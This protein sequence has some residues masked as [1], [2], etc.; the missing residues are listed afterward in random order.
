MT[1]QNQ[2][3]SNN[4]RPVTFPTDSV[5]GG[6]N[7]SSF[8]RIKHL[9]F[10]YPFRPLISSY[11]SCRNFLKLFCNLQFTPAYDSQRRSILKTTEEIWKKSYY[12]NMPFPQNPTR[13][14]SR[15]TT[16]VCTG[17]LDLPNSSNKHMLNLGLESGKPTSVSNSSPATAR[18]LSKANRN[19][20]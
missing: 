14:K 20:R 16:K 8:D 5:T 10:R 7:T 4:T 9:S 2:P 12:E 18:N 6:T 17:Q 11:R 13:P 19:T 3:I 15:Q 1:H